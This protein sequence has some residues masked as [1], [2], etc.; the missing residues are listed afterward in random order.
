[1]PVRHAGLGLRPA[2]TVS[3]S[4]YV[5]SLAAC[6][7]GLLDVA[8]RMHKRF[9]VNEDDGQILESGHDPDETEVLW[10]PERYRREYAYCRNEL[11]KR[12]PA[13]EEMTFTDQ[14]DPDGADQL[15]CLPTNLNLF[16]RTFQENPALKR[17]LQARLLEPVWKAEH[18]AIATEL[19]LGPDPVLAAA[20]VARLDAYSK[21][22]A[23]R[24]LNVIPS[25][26]MTIFTGEELKQSVRE[27][28]GLM[29]AASFYLISGPIICREGDKVDLKSVPTHSGRHCVSS[30]RGVTTNT[31]DGAAQ[32]FCTIGERNGVPTSWT[33][34]LPGGK[35]LDLGFS[36]TDG[37]VQAD[38]T[39]RS[40]DAPSHAGEAARHGADGVLQAADSS[41]DK[42][43]AHLVN[44]PGTQFVALSFLNSGAYGKQVGML[45]KR[46]CQTG[47]ALGVTRPVDL[48]TAREWLAVAI[49]RG[50]ARAALWG[51]ARMRAVNPAYKAAVAAK[52]RNR[53]RR[54]LQGSGNGEG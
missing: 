39:I 2:A 48:K 17:K 27:R 43:Y 37:F 41:K 33:P 26:A 3:L 54:L 51:A 11:L 8:A 10:L 25:S 4:A 18:E 1:M 28:F 12:A 23:G 47:E 45:L 21:P 5:A 9:G 22:T 29:P 34:Y 53:A 19:S 6:A 50:R 44:G 24:E 30:R 52:R 46:I 14:E 16:L 35:V 13:L 40:A 49:Q 31:H 38:V 20:D 15:K 36:F 7:D 32:T 42:R